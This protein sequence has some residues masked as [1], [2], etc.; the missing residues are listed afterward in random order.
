MY[1]GSELRKKKILVKVLMQQNFALN[2]ALPPPRKNSKVLWHTL[3]S[4][5]GA[6]PVVFSFEVMTVTKVKQNRNIVNLL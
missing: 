6:A 5:T 3:V 4:V 1:F 2:I